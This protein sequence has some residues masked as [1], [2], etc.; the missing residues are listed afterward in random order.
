MKKQIAKITLFGLVAAALVAVPAA[1]RAEDSTN[2]PAAAPANKH[3]TPFHGK[4]T[5]VD[6][7]AMTLTV[8][9]LT[10]NITSETKITKDNKPA[11]LSDI[12]VGDTVRGAYKTDDA[13][14]LN[15]TVIRDGLKTGTTKKKKPDTDGGT[16]TNSVPN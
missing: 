10:I 16:S 9:S 3:G 7:N 15:A 11:T 8:K 13:G 12:A 14:K 1:S 6:T 5:D 4:V 2:A